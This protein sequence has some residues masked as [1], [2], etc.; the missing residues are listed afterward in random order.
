MYRA[1][2]VRVRTP[3]EPSCDVGPHGRQRPSGKDLTANGRL[4]GD[5]EQLAGYDFD[6]NE[7]VSSAGACQGRVHARTQ[8]VH[9][10]V[11]DVGSIICMDDECERVHRL[12]VEQ[13]S[14]LQGVPAS[15][16]LV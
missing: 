16:R 15:Q 6:Y 10:A 8:L 7:A 12:A 5:L 14:H 2:R 11:T 13:E 9:P 4:D 3:V 1:G